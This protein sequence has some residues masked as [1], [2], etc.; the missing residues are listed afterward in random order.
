MQ[1]E[2][3]F[4]NEQ[5]NRPMEINSDLIAKSIA[6]SLGFLRSVLVL[7]STLLGFL[8]S[9][10][11]TATRSPAY[12]ACMA[13]SVLLLSLAILLSTFLLYI[14]GPWRADRDCRSFQR[15]AI[16]ELRA[17]HPTVTTGLPLPAWV[18]AVE[19]ASAICFATS[20]ALLAA[21]YC[22]RLCQATTA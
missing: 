19:A 11:Q 21:S 4:T 14:H 20:L 8:V 2:P 13:T 5:L 9:F 22:I 6:Q 10:P 7:S 18:R 15:R 12:H 1:T 17:G 3:P 16:P